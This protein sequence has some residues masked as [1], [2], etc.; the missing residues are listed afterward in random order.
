MHVHVQLGSDPALVMRRPQLGAW[1]W[2]MVKCRRM[3]AMNMLIDS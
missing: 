2:H 3:V 1:P